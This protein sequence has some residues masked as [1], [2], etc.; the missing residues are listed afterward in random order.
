MYTRNRSD[1]LCAGRRVDGGNVQAVADRTNE[2]VGGAPRTAAVFLL[3]AGD[4]RVHRMVWMWLCVGDCSSSRAS[5][6]GPVGQ[7]Q[8][9][10]L[11]LWAEQHI[12][13]TRSDS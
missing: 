3:Y 6:R 7:P 13:S 10:L 5:Q 1:G 12:Q 2:G 9:G 8:D 4:C 11:Q